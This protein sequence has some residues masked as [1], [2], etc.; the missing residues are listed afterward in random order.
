MDDLEQK[1]AQPIIIILLNHGAELQYYAY[2]I[3]DNQYRGAGLVASAEFRDGDDGTELQVC[4]ERNMI[5]SLSISS[6]LV[7]AG[8]AQ[9]DPTFILLRVGELLSEPSR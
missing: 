7:C 1:N 2:Q 4:R 6:H 5:P 9:P 8:T 3:K